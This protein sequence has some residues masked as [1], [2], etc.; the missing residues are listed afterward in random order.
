MSL[1]SNLKRHFS[2]ISIKIMLMIVKRGKVRPKRGLI[3]I[4]GNIL[5]GIAHDLF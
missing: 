2:E 1:K 4:K 3:Q 5:R